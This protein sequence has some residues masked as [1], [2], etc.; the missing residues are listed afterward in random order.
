MRFEVQMPPRPLRL[1]PT[2]FSDLVKRRQDQSS[3]GGELC[4]EG[5]A[6]EQDSRH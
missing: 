4:Q 2:T 1:Q 5:A 6:I 3:H